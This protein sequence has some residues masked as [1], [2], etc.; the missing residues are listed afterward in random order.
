V[1]RH[2][3]A[4]VFVVALLLLVFGVAFLAEDAVTD[5]NARATLVVAF[6]GISSWIVYEREMRG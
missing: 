4:T 3:F 1:S 6:A 2:L 5:L